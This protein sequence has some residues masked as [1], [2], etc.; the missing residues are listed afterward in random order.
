[1]I[2]LAKDTREA[3]GPFADKVEN[4]SLLFE[5]MVLAKT[6]GHEG[7]FNDANRFIYCVR[8]VMGRSYWERIEMARKG[9]Q[10]GGGNAANEAYKAK[11]AGALAA[12]ALN[13]DSPALLRRQ[14]ENANHL[15]ELMEKAYRGRVKT[16]V[17]TL[18]GRLLVNM[19][20]GVMENAGIAL[21]RCFGLPFIPGSAVKG[22]ARN[23]ALWD[24]HRTEDRKEKATKLRQ[25]LLA[26][27][28]IGQDIRGTAIIAG[29][30][31]TSP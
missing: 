25:A 9:K 17:G 21:D 23:Q 8:P 31:V 22:I 29:R 10:T 13:V 6:W 27:G 26:F 1:M 2:P 28:F 4:R 18:G 16:F 3:I 30:P 19:A 12:G 24:I 15:L 11:V 7:R 5:K 20:G 14:T